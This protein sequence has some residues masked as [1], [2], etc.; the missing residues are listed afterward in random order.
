LQGVS[1]SFSAQTD[2]DATYVWFHFLSK[3][4]HMSH[5]QIV[6]LP[7]PGSLSNHIQEDHLRAQRQ[8]Q[9][10]F[11]WLK[12][13]FVLRIRNPPNL[14]AMPVRTTSS[15]SEST[16]T[17]ASIHSEVEMFCFGA[18]T[19]IRDRFQKFKSTASCEDILLDPYVLLEIVISEMHKEMDRTGWK[20]ADVFSEIETV[21]NGNA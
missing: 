14:L 19:S 16:L 18:P 10:N 15:S 21:S 3:T 4:C 2:A 13:G 9:A 5:G 7:E 17:P 1:Q 11:T 20:I 6:H 8:S 12:P